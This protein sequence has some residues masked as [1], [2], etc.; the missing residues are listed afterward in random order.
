MLETVLS[1]TVFGLFPIPLAL[2]AASSNLERDNA[3]RHCDHERI[4]VRRGVG[5]HT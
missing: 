2:L 1:E 4:E 5:S 3:G